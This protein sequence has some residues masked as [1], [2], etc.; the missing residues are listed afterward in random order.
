M[1][2]IKT[3]FI[4]SLIL[5]SNFIYAQKIEITEKN[6]FKIFK[7]TIEQENKN[8]IKTV[9]NPWIADN[10]NDVFSKSDTI[11]FTNGKNNHYCK[12][13]NWT[14]YRKNKFI[15][16]YGDFCSEPTSYTVTKIQDYF[17]IKINE[18]D[19]RKYFELY[20]QG[21]LI[22]KFEIISLEKSQSLSYKN[23]IEYTLKLRRIRDF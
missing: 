9:S 5:F 22:D 2:S 18:M 12:D 4:L 11:I 21:K 17:E 16:N 8:Q 7:K 3:I 1:K 15:R 14:F 10:S 19:T 20:N 6:L 13:V 23:L